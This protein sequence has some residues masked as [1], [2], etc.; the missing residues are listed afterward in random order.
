MGRLNFNNPTRRDT[1]VMPAKGWLALAF[2]VDNPGAWLFHCHIAWHAGQGLSMQFLETVS[3]I[4][5]TVN[6]AELEPTCSI[7]TQYYATSQCKQWD[8]GL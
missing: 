3:E 5:G 2:R 1:T 7:W 8:S 6:L 4:P